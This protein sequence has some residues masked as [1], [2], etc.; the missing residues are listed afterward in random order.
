MSRLAL[1]PAQLASIDFD[2]F[3][4]PK[5]RLLL[6]TFGSTSVTVAG[7][8]AL[9]LFSDSC[10]PKTNP[11]IAEVRAEVEAFNADPISGWCD[12]FIAT[13]EREQAALAAERDALAERR[14]TLVRAYDNAGHATLRAR[15]E[16]RAAAA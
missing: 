9:E 14:Q 13:N 6:V 7:G 2:T 10:S 16:A 1:S 12:L 5:L 3:T 4:F 15:R 11:V 8:P